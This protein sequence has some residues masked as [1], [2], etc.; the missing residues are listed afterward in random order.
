MTTNWLCSDLPERGSAR[1]Q[2]CVGIV[3]SF[4]VWKGD[5]SEAISSES[6]SR[7]SLLF[8]S[9]IIVTQCHCY[10]V[11]LLLHSVII[12]AQCR[13]YY[14]VSLLLRSVIIITQC[15]YYYAVS[16]LLHSVIII[17]QCHYCYTRVIIVTHVSLL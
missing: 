11:S 10:T 12:V 15:H 4:R 8:H 2:H 16:L 6:L 14:A 5:D 3:T 7:V 13:Y 9:V 1:W 17:T